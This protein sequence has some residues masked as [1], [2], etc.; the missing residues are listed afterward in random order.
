MAPQPLTEVEI[1]EVLSGLPGWTLANDRL[2]REY[3]LAGHLPAVA[4]LVHV[5][6]VQE[7]LNHHADLALTY[8]RL[9]VAVNTHSVGG[10][11]TELDAQLATRIE[12]LA[13]A[14]GAS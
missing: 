6:T 11:V 13:A 4:M 14:H 8:N 9:G 7:E 2:V 10:R 1:A 5:A 3:R 12:E